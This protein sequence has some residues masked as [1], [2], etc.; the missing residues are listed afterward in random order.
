MKTIRKDDEEYPIMLNGIKNAP[1]ELY[2][3]GNIRCFNMPCVTVVGSRDMT[4]YGKSMARKIV[5]ELT[6]AGVCIVSG[7]A[8]G[9]DSIAHQ[10]CLDNG[11]KTIAVLGSGLR[12][13]YPAE[14][15]KLYKDIIRSGGC[16][17]SEQE[18]ETEA[19][20]MFFPARNRI[21][22]GLS[23]GTLVI[24]ATYRSGT[25]ITAK[26][27]FEQGRK[28]FCIPNS[29]GNKNSSGTLNLIKKGADMVTNGKEILYKL[30]LIKVIDNYDEL[31]EEERLNKINLM[32]EEAL[33][34]IR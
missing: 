18:P 10:T 23:L 16:A 20:K 7:L 25:S 21:V 14:N 13:V 22:S 30:G 9:I 5:K 31:M 34:W 4:E 17:I 11:G 29:I 2:V 33:R 12:K 3:E 8:V 28:V 15:V 6:L 1:Q 24:E 26:F 32:E 27:A 19:Q